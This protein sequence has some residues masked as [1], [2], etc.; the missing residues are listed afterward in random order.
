M[1]KSQNEDMKNLKLSGKKG[2]NLT[3]SYL[4]LILLYLIFFMTYY[5]VI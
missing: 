2:K 1:A 4:F 5:V 3:V